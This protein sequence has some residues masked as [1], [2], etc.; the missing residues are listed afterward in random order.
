MKPGDVRLPPALAQRL[1]ARAR[2]LLPLGTI[3]EDAHAPDAAERAALA[4]EYGL[5][6]EDSDGWLNFVTAPDG[7]PGAERVLGT[8]RRLGL[9]VAAM[10][11]GCRNLEDL[12]LRLTHRSLRD[13]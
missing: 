6:G 5:A 12:F 9:E 2:A 3:T 4:E 8:L 7:S 1:D 11:M 13:D 10:Q